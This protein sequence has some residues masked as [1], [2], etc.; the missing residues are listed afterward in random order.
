[1]VKNKK[2]TEDTMMDSQRNVTGIGAG[3]KDDPFVQI[4]VPIKRQLGDMNANTNF[5]HEIALY[6]QQIFYIFEQIIILRNQVD[7]AFKNPS[8]KE[9]QKVG[10]D[11]TLNSLDEVC[12]KLMDIPNFLSLFSVD[13]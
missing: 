4:S 7:A 10:L 11:K 13:K 1:V 2:L 6:K 9:S 3:A 12:M 8:V 5:P